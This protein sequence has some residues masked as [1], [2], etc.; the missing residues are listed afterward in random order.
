M[1]EVLRFL[2]ETY[3]FHQVDRAD[4]EMILKVGNEEAYDAEEEIV[5]EGDLGDA[6]FVI[7]DGSVD[8]VKKGT[9]GPV[10]LARLQPKD[11]FGEMALIDLEPR[12]ASSVASKQTKVRRF[13][14]DQICSVLEGNTKVLS[15]LITRIAKHLSRRLRMANEQILSL[16]ESGGSKAVS[17]Q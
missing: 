16:M 5:G 14:S 1:K 2:S 12:S 6:L 17:S 9:K 15:L 10:K 11:F 3:L 4:L 13:P 7:L 8:I